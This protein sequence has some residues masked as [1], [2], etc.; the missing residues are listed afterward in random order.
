[1]GR[2]SRC[3]RN[4]WLRRRKDNK[5]VNGTGINE[6]PVW[7]R[8]SFVRDVQPAFFTH[9]I[10]RLTRVSNAVLFVPLQS[11]LIAP[12]SLTETIPTPPSLPRSSATFTTVER[13]PSKSTSSASPSPAKSSLRN[14]RSQK[15]LSSISTRDTG[16]EAAWGSNF[17]VT[18]VDPQA[19]PLRLFLRSDWLSKKHPDSDVLLCMPCNWTGQLGPSCGS[20]GILSTHIVYP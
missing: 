18:L 9:A 11:R 19:S 12:M 4:L 14:P 13:T 10:R 16:D 7:D 1:M 6:L 15:S 20:V 5:Y 17:W 8:A 2:M 3:W